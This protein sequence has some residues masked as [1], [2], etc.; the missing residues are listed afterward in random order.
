VSPLPLQQQGLQQPPPQQPQH[1]GW[2]SW[3][4]QQQ[5]QGGQEGGAWAQQQQQPQLQAQQDA[6]LHRLLQLQQYQQL[7]QKLQQQGAVSGDAADGWDSG[8]GPILQPRLSGGALSQQPELSYSTG[9]C[10]C[11][12]LSKTAC[13][14]RLC[15]WL[16]V[17][18]CSSVG[19]PTVFAPLLCASPYQDR[20]AKRR[21][22]RTPFYPACSP[23]APLLPALRAP[24]STPSG[25]LW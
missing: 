10:V 11:L 13:C 18:A 6:T 5:A 21:R 3:Q 4:V 7:H 8:G 2:G 17:C 19:A 23:Q 16:C 1:A 14:L 25:T 12:S 24:A 15:L 22:M 9:V 20:T